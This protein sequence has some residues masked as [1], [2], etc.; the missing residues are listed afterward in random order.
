MWD[1]ITTKPCTLLTKCPFPKTRRYGPLSGATSSSCGGLRPLTE[2]FFA[3][4]AKK[5]AYYAVLAHFWQF[6]VSNSNLGNFF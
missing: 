6:L 5:R 4:H 3:L 1:S 2:A